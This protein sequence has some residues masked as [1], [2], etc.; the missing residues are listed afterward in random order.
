MTMTDFIQLDGD[1]W[2]AI[3]DQM[4]SEVGIDAITIEQATRINGSPGPLKVVL[5][6]Q[7]HAFKQF[8]VHE[9]ANVTVRW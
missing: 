3:T 5:V 1:Q 9:D 2:Q 6:S 4:P 8:V 7:G